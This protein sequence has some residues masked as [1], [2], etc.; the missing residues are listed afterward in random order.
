MLKE[1]IHS[2]NADIIGLQEVA[3]G[4][5]SLDNLIRIDD[6][7]KKNP[8][9]SGPCEQSQMK[10]FTAHESP[11]QINATSV[12][13]SAD[14]NFRIDGNAVLTDNSKFAKIISNEV[15]HLSAIRNA[16]M[17]KI[18]DT[19]GS[20]IVIVNTHLHHPI[21]AEDEYVRGMQIWQVLFWIG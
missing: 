6:D 18:E 7:N 16:Q 13:Q 9:E 8:S 17:V 10:E 21:A 11:V 2:L 4:D 15:L 12:W 19:A 5:Y 3:F 20:D 1:T 14:P